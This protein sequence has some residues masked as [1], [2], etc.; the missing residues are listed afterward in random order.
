MRVDFVA[1]SG[2]G[3]RAIYTE[4]TMPYCGMLEAM[5]AQ[6]SANQ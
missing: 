1:R 2:D 5:M 3:E 6:W 4:L